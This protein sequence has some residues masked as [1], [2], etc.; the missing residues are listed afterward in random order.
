MEEPS[1]MAYKLTHV[2]AYKVFSPPKLSDLPY[3]H[4]NHDTALALEEVEPHPQ[5]IPVAHLG[6]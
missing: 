4:Q 3:T 1:E 6:Q 5:P 2:E